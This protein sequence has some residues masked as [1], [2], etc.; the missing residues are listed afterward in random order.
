MNNKLIYESLQGVANSTEKRNKLV[1]AYMEPHR[2]YHNLEH[3]SEILENIEHVAHY[4]ALPPFMTLHLMTVAWYHDVV[5]QVGSQE[6]EAASADMYA[7]D[8]GTGY[9][10]ETYNAILDTQ[11]HKSPSSWLSAIFIDLDLAGLGSS[12]Y[13]VNSEKIKKEFMPVLIERLDGD[14]T[15]ARKQFDEGRKAFLKGMTQRRAIFKTAWGAQ[16]EQRARSEMS[17]ELSRLT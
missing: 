4:L 14:R 7:A 15:E 1:Q 13:A 11:D 2:V 3:V 5:Y 8:Y 17:N 9:R 10:E 12:N 6:N 16:F